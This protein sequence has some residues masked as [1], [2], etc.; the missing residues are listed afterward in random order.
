MNSGIYN[1]KIT[2]I[3]VSFHS[4]QIIENL[5]NSIEKNIKIL[6]V[7]NSLD[8]KLKIDLE[9]KFK[10]VQVIIPKRNLG[11]GGGINFGMR[12]VKTKFSLYLDADVI[13]DK[14]M[15]NV[16]LKNTEK[17]NNFFI[18]A[19]KEQNYRYG[20]DQYIKYDKNK[21]CHKMRFIAGCALLFNMKSLNKTGY[22]D[23]NIFLYYEEHDLYYRCLKLGLDIYLIDDAKFIH[24]GTSS[25]N[26]EHNHEIFLNRN[27][28]YC[29]SK[30]YYFKKNYGYF[31]GIRKTF[32]NF[33][34]ALR[35]YLF[36]KLL[37]N[38]KNSALHMA[39]MQGLTASYFL[40]KSLRRPKINI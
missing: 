29:W 38:K 36:Y 5:I 15:T 37:G 39:E 13:P 24:H 33:L 34:R 22:F 3:I 27:W 18:L 21:S 25:T 12:L 30:F 4:N 23:E 40:K 17:I 8:Q 26:K 2:I 28:H 9:K 7:E 1:D 20:K 16:L 32:P 11:N 14:N 35:K 19:P 10:N 31:Y 6:I